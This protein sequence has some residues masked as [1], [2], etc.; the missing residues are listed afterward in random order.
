MGCFPLSIPV[1]YLRLDS[2]ENGVS[3]FQELCFHGLP[4]IIVKSAD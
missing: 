3:D 4:M 1:L 2:G